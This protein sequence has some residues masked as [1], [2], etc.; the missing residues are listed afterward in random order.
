MDSAARIFAIV[1]AAGS[2]SRMAA[3]VSKVFLPIGEESVVARTVRVLGSAAQ[4]AGIV[5]MCSAVDRE[6]M[7]QEVSTLH[8]NVDVA[9]GG[10]TRQESV[11]AGLA[12][13][14]AR[15]SPSS[16]DI[17]LIH[18]AARCFVSPDVVTRCVAG[19]LKHGA[20]TAAVPIVDSVLRA[21]DDKSCAGWVDRTGM[22][23]VQT[24]QAFRYDLLSQAHHVATPGATDDASLVAAIHPVKV[25][26]GA[27]ENIKITVPADFEFAKS[28]LLPRS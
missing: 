5:V 10:A 22:W 4:F 23:A 28:F 19:A 14:A 15:Y 26:E 20:V 24:P 7:H 1:P 27:R 16:P 2:G 8:P 12:F 21:G 11:R 6:R 17:V 18:D 25:V 3:T 13:L 9:L